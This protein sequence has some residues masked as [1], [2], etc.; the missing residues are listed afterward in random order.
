MG[1]KKKHNNQGPDINVFQLLM[2]RYYPYWPLFAIAS[3]SML[4][5]AWIYLQL[6][7][8]V[9]EATATLIIKDERKGVENAKMVESLNVYT[10]KKIVENEI[11]VLKSR[12][13]LRE[14][15]RILHLTSPV[16]ED[17]L[18]FSYSAYTSSPV[19]V[20]V[21]NMDAMVEEKR[22]EIFYNQKN[23]QV[24]FEGQPYPL[25]TWIDTPYGQIRFIKN[26][27]LTRPSNKQLFVSFLD[28]QNVMEDLLNNISIL[29][30]NK[31]STVI[32]LSFKD[33]IPLK[34]ENILNTLMESY[35]RASIND[36][37]SL[38]S[39]TLEF[40]ESRIT[41]IEHELDSLE[42]VIELYKTSEGIVD[43]S[44]QGKVFLKNV[45]DNDQRLT[46]L[47]MQLAALDRV[48]EY[49]VQKGTSEKLV[50]TTLGLDDSGLAALIKKLY[51]AEIEFARL[52]QTTAQ[53]NPILVSLRLNL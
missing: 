21:S 14:T 50:P 10:S 26:P 15:A 12:S 18:V 23:Q 9:Y 43:L 33:P 30:S 20:E 41:L 34:A 6:A 53:N 3:V 42:H 28:P 8:P 13:L 25:D 5:V 45:A 40:V 19:I 16:S 52:K 27:Y 2:F 35:N 4:L 51:D 37:N 1:R 24:Q 36:K 39:N 7:S 17:G 47:N 29:P 46:E 22:I 49:L 44:E 32:N 38:A 31:L 48:E 11:E